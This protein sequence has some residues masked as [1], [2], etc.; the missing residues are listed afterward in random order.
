M[1]TRQTFFTIDDKVLFWFDAR[2]LGGPSD[3]KA[4]NAKVW[5]LD[6]EVI[7]K[8]YGAILVHRDGHVGW[9]CLLAG[10]KGVSRGDCETYLSSIG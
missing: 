1:R 10:L 4:A 8:A 7:S 2:F 5:V 6:V 3:V 9:F